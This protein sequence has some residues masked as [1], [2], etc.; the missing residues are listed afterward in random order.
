[1]QIFKTGLFSFVSMLCVQIF[2]KLLCH[3]CYLWC[4]V[5]SSGFTEC[6]MCCGCF[7]PGSSL[8][9][10]KLLLSFYALKIK[11]LCILILKICRCPPLSS[12]LCTNWNELIIETTKEEKGHAWC[13]FFSFNPPILTA[14]LRGPMHRNLRKYQHAHKTQQKLK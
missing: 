3:C 1:M 10:T 8:H 5:G 2:A 6:S 14:S 13:C 12:S 9:F 11:I 4:C 7:Y